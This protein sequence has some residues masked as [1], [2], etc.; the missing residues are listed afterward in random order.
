VRAATKEV[1]IM[2]RLAVVMWLALAGAGVGACS[3]P[4]HEAAERKTEC[5]GTKHTPPQSCSGKNECRANC[6]LNATCEE[7]EHTG[8]D[9][10]L[11]T[12]YLVCG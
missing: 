10:G 8:T 4:C 2:K 9:T 6:E 3:N 1:T 5:S 12:C 7:L 11:Y